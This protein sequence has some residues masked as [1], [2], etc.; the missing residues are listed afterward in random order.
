MGGAAL[1]EHAAGRV[2]SSQGQQ[3]RSE[4]RSEVQYPIGQAPQ[5]AIARV[6]VIPASFATQADIDGYASTVV[7]LD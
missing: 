4:I 2:R 6:P 1:L 7:R 5:T 3:R